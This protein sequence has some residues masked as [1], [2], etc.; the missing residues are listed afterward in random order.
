MAIAAAPVLVFGPPGW[1]V[2]GLAVAGTA[3]AGAWV[4]S[5]SSSRPATST[6]TPT[7]TKDACITK[8]EP[9]RP[10]AVRVHAQGT[11]MGGTSGSTLGAPPLVQTS[12]PISVAQGIEL[13]S[14]TYALLARRPS[15]NL[16]AAYEKCVAFIG[17]HRPYGWLG[18][19]SFYGLK[20]GNNRFDVDSY[21]PGPNFLE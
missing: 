19:R 8:C 7:A 18:Q 16:A 3:I 21:G 9:K 17:S 13:A 15:V 12:G 1:V 4:V 11:D 6:S 5:Q 20:G 14:A 10:W 2:F